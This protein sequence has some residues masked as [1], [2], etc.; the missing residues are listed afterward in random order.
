MVY[1][2]P[3]QSAVN[4]SDDVM[5]QC[6]QAWAWPARPMMAATTGS[7]NMV[8]ESGGVNARSFSSQKKTGKEKRF[9]FQQSI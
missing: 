4:A 1:V 6:I 5:L 9:F 7:G 3:S 8:C 2:A